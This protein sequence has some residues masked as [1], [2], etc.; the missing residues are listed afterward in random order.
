M[1]QGPKGEGTHSSDL[2]Q[3]IAIVKSFL[4]ERGFC[5]LHP[6]LMFSSFFSVTPRMQ[7]VPLL[8][9]PPLPKSF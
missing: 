5:C 3:P 2:L 7:Q 6:E 1:L 9:S 8:F 4:R